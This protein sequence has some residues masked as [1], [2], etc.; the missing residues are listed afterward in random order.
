MKKAE[1]IQG[2]ILIVL[3]VVA[4]LIGGLFELARNTTLDGS[5]DMY[6]TQFIAAIISVVIGVIL[7]VAGILRIYFARQR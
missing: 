3:A 6:L 5:P 2:I 7:L 1:L 4:F